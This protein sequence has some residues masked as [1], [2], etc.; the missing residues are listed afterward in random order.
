[1]HCYKKMR[2][3]YFS[4]LCALG[5]FVGIQINAAVAEGI[6]VVKTDARAVDEGIEVS[7]DFKITLPPLVAEALTHGVVLNFVSEL[8]VMRSRWYWLDTVVMQKEQTSKLSY[9]ALTRQYRISRGTLFQSFLNLD[10]ALK[11]LG[12]QPRATVAVESFNKGGGYVA[13]FLN[14]E[15]KYTAFV[16][17]RLDTSQLPKP[18]QV[19]ALTNSDWSVDSSKHSWLLRPEKLELEGASTP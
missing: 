14:S 12:R 10:S 5:L 4:I 13:K 8:T 17:M 11:V 16:E 7:A 15:T 18:L 1:M 2:N 9:N 3:V 19:N 6:E